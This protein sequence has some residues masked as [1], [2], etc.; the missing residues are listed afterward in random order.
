M[1]NV[2]MIAAIGKNNE[3]GIGN[4]LIWH[5]PGDLKFFKDVTMGH[6]IVMG[7]NTFY[8]LPR[9][10]PGRK[11]I[12]LTSKNIDNNEVLVIHNRDELIRY[13][14]SKKEEVM[15]I[16]GSSIYTQM[17]DLA[18]KLYLTEI[19]ATCSKA[20]CYFP[21]IDYENWDS[22]VLGNNFDNG[23]NYK[24]VLYKRKKLMK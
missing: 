19:N 2:S 5:L 20:D 14:K 21:K 11:H 12:V 8:S 10:L 6:E 22:Q 9:L 18:N 23:I 24:H 17:F 3:L 7:S 16:G 4:E 15:I 1:E 13:L